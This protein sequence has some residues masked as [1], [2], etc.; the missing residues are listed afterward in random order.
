VLDR[1]L[2]DGRLAW[3]VVGERRG[4]AGAGVQ[5]FTV[6]E[7]AQSAIG[8]EGARYSREVYRRSTAV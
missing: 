1:T 2:E 8:R 3:L 7:E 6:S 5:G 4:A